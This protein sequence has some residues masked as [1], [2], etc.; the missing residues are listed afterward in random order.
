MTRRGAALVDHPVVRAVLFERLLLTASAALAFVALATGRVRPA[1]IP[2]LLDWRLLGLFFVL[3]VAVELGKDSGLF[4]RLVEAAVRRA[5]NVRTLALALVAVTA[6]LAALLTN[7]V[8][9]MLVVPFT[10]LLRRAADL[11]PAP[12]VVLEIGA[13]NVLGALTP[14]GNPQNLF[15]FTRGGFTPG[16]FLAAQLPFV[17]GAAVLLA[18]AVPAIVPR[19]DF[20]P[21]ASMRAGVDAR[22]AAAFGVLLA[23]EIAALAGAIPWPVPLVLS[24]GGAAVLGRRV[25][26]ADFSL[27]PVFAFLF[28]GVAGLERGRVYRALDPG[29]LFGHAPTGIT[30]SGAVLSQLVSNVPAALLLAPAVHTAQGFRALLYGVNAGGCGTPIASIANLIGWQLFRRES[31]SAGRFWRLFLPVSF[32]LLAALLLWSLAIL[33]LPIG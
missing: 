26:D 18:A 8:A 13:A 3:T 19:H 31:G 15:L 22:L 32:A 10:M 29:R 11:D 7:D 28:V 4:D 25:F 30:V 33:R 23:A 27:V 14:V 9:L 1:E 2:A 24:L 5:R 17:A 21:P 20:P 6:L 12:I 16:G